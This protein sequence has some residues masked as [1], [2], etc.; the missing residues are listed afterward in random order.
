MSYLRLREM[1]VD[2]AAVG[3]RI[4][5]TNKS[6]YP[7]ELSTGEIVASYEEFL[8]SDHWVN[9]KNQYFKSIFSKSQIKR[10][11]FKFK[12]L[13]IGNCQVC[14][15]KDYAL[16]IHHLTYKNFGNENLEDLRHLCKKCHKLQHE[17]ENEW[18]S[19]TLFEIF[20]VTQKQHKKEQKRKTSKK[21]E[22]VRKH[23]KIVKRNKQKQ[24]K[25]SKSERKKREL[26]Q[27]KGYNID[28]EAKY[29]R[30]KQAKAKSYKRPHSEL[31]NYGPL[32]SD[33][34]FQKRTEEQ[35]KKDKEEFKLALKQ[36]ND[37]LQKKGDNP[38]TLDDKDR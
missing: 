24:R 14:N 37:I 12:R 9:K 7:A 1:L 8:K 36:T 22:K 18:P 23:N 17:K 19:L 15:K 31:Q 21:V 30:E 26:L 28:W 5:N 6:T 20:K 27:K 10:N 16:Q 2:L 33:L 29:Y 34:V 13:N 4:V 32:M 38:F 25:L 3:S 35:L 11:N